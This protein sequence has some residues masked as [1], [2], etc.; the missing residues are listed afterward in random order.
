[1]AIYRTNR[2]RTTSFIGKFKFNYEV[3]LGNPIKNFS[4]PIFV[5]SYPTNA[6]VVFSSTDCSFVC[7]V[8]EPNL[9]VSNT[10]GR[11][12]VFLEPEYVESSKKYKIKLNFQFIA[13]ISQGQNAVNISDSFVLELVDF[14]KNVATKTL[15]SFSGSIEGTVYFGTPLEEYV[16]IDEFLPSEI[17]TKPSASGC[18]DDE[19]VVIKDL[20]KDTS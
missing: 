18:G 9:T 14:D 1:M 16:G 15:K 10:F 19:I 8:G 13:G 4:F 20:N 5:K 3:L 11:D 12:T 2:S 17:K 6:E 7:R